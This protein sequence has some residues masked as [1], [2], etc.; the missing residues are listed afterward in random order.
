MAGWRTWLNWNL[1]G[2]TRAARL[3][4]AG[5][6]ASFI[7]DHASALSMY[8]KSL[9][10]FRGFER[11][12][13]VLELRIKIGATCQA[14]GEFTAART[15][16]EQAVSLAR[17]QKSLTQL[18]MALCGLASVTAC[19]G[20]YALARRLCTECLGIWS[21]PEQ[22]LGVAAVQTI[23]GQMAET[24]AAAREQ[25]MSALKIYQDKGYQDGIVAT[26]CSLGHLAEAGADNAKERAALEE[27][28]EFCDVSD[29]IKT[30]AYA[31]NNLGNIERF[32]GQLD[33]AQELYRDSLHLKQQ[34]NDAWAIAYTLDG[35]AAITLERGQS[36]NSARLLGRAAAIRERL[37]TP[38]EPHMRQEIQALH[39]QT[40][41]SLNPIDFEAAWLA[42]ERMTTNEAIDEA[43]HE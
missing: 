10:L 5:N 6:D 41:A 4:E 33:K 22:V 13:A 21:D 34:I 12:D 14:L 31:L 7:D 18:P 28:L 1:G 36:T 15:H 40:R 42:G 3:F 39:E 25:Y 23:M 20:D 43:L 11:W 30:R 37:G 32:A 9:D 38:L 8:E 2:G 27:C 29:S 17:N 16:Y 35:C 19:Q 24:K 26:L